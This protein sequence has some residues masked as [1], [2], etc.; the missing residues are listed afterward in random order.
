MRVR[1]IEKHKQAV[2]ADVMVRIAKYESAK[3]LRYLKVT[4]APILGLLALLILAI[5]TMAPWRDVAVA[6]LLDAMFIT[7]AFGILYTERISVAVPSPL[8]EVVI[9]CWICHDP[10]RRKEMRQH[11]ATVHPPY[12]RY[13]RSS[14]YVVYGFLFGWIVTLFLLF[15]LLLFGALPESS[16]DLFPS[17]VLGPLAA[18]A[19]GGLLWALI[20][21]PHYALKS[22]DQWRRQHPTKEG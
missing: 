13:L 5:W 1:D 21:H 10:S 12:A 20:G 8:Q 14:V 9:R 2:H 16:W 17:L 7:A 18:F 15:N 19:I 4:I 6:I 22:R 3:G 11:L